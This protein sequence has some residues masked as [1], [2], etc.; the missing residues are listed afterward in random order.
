MKK[1]IPFVLML[2]AFAGFQM[3]YSGTGNRT[4][5]FSPVTAAVV[6]DNTVDTAAIVDEAVTLAKMADGDEVGDMLYW[7][8][9]GWAADPAPVMGDGGG[10]NLGSGKGGIKLRDLATDIIEIENALLEI[11]QQVDDFP[12]V[13]TTII[14]TLQIFGDDDTAGADEIAFELVT[15]ATSTWTNGDEDS[16][17]VLSVLNNGVLNANQFVLHTDGTV[18]TS[19]AFLPTDLVIPQA[20]PAVPGVDGAVEVDFTDGALVMQHGSAHA[21]LA[22]ATDVVMGKLI[23]SYTATLAMPDLLQA[24]IDN[25]LFKPI[26]AREFP[27]G[28][29]VTAI[30][31][32]TSASSTFAINVENWDDPTTINGVNGTIDAI[33]TSG[34]TE[35][36]ED[37]ITY[38]TI[39]AGQIIMIDL[40]TTDLSW[41]SVTI[42]YYEPAA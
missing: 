29:V 22:S 42:F 15:T 34:S 13:N 5:D 36:T 3:A 32:A 20:S 23:K 12:I 24:E 14:G 6:E 11:Q 17:A 40:P 21:E 39:G 26:D 31:L 38:A 9:A 19:G 30:Y 27:H 37:T 4:Y 33:T 8:L 41:A 7:T 10:P 16:Q 35:A 25:W 1:L 18:S 28:I 2:S